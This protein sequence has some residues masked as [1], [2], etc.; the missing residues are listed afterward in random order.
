ML[1]KDY[2]CKVFSWEKRAGRDPQE[3]CR[4]DEVIGCKPPVVK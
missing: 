1:N 4:Q 2:D 3:A